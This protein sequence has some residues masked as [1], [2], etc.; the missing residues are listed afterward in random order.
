V[1]LDLA[2]RKV[3]GWGLS[4]TMN[5]KDTT[6]AALEMA[7]AVARSSLGYRTPAQMEQL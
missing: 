2:N 6:I 7:A 4:K 3:I 5:A 1:V